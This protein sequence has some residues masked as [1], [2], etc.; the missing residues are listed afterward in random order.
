MWLISG[1]RKRLWWIEDGQSNWHKKPWELS[2]LYRWAVV[3][4]HPSRHILP[5]L[6]NENVLAILSSFQ[7]ITL[8]CPV[9]FWL[10]SVRGFSIS[11]VSWWRYVRYFIAFPGTTPLM[12]VHSFLDWRCHL[13][14]RLTVPQTL[15]DDV[16]PRRE[17]LLAPHSTHIPWFY[18]NPFCA[19][20]FWRPIRPYLSCLG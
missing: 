3:F 1:R 8:L 6:F 19:Q 7:P 9:V 13:W 16:G 15:H 20:Q 11:V 14:T 10:W 18:H 4:V 17:Q 2:G 12:W 5:Q